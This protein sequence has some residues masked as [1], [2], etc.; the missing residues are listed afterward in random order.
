[1]RAKGLQAGFRQIL[2][3]LAAVSLVSGALS[4]AEDKFPNELASPIDEPQVVMRLLKW[5]LMRLLPTASNPSFSGTSIVW[6]IRQG[7]R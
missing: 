7:P 4:R 3:L 6:S 1:M 5:W 2:P